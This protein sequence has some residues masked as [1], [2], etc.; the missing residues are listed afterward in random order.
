MKSMLPQGVTY[1]FYRHRDMK[2]KEERA[3]SKDFFI[4]IMGVI[5]VIS[6]IPPAAE[7]SIDK[8]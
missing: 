1:F 6:V 3:E 5:R 2:R 4:G 7:I 8:I